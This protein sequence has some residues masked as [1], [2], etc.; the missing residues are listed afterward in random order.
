MYKKGFLSL[1]ILE[2]HAGDGFTGSP[3][4]LG[5]ILAY[6][7]WDSGALNDV[8]LIVAKNPVEPVKKN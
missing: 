2:P 4:P 3:E 7:L 6:C 5:T 8:R 1:V